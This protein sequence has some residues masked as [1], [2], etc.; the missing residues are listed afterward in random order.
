MR[1]PHLPAALLALAASG[2][3][4]G[5]VTYDF[6]G[7]TY[8][9]GSLRQFTGVF[10]YEDAVA[11][12]T[13]YYPGNTYPVQQGFRSTYAGSIRELSITLLGDSHGHESVSTSAGGNIDVNNTIEAPPGAQVPAGLSVQAWAGSASG[14]INGQAIDMLYLAFLP[15]QPN[16]SWYD[17]DIFF[18]GNAETILQTTPGALPTDINTAWTGTTLSPS[19]EMLASSLFLGTIH[20]SSQGVTTT[21]NNI[22]SF[23]LRVPTP[24]SAL[25]LGFAGLVGTRRRR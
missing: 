22:T 9:G 3:A 19:I 6:T 15:V 16:F 14:T 23:Q 7:T 13:T 4:A 21:V 5:V 12:A 18:N 24:G 20:T 10:S 17:L 8:V 25:V 11:S 1:I 2:A